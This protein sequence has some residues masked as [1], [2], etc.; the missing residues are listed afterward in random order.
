MIYVTSDLHGCHP[1]EFQRF[2]TQ[3]GFGD[4]DFLFILGDVIDRGEYGAELLLWL[5]EQPNMQ[6]ILGNHEALLL[7]CSFLFDEVTEESLEALNCE[8]LRLM[9]GWMKNGASPTIA[10]FRKL[11]RRDPELVAGILDY[12]QDAPLYEMLEI[13]G[14]KYVLVHAGLDNFHPA[15]P[16][17]DYAPDG[18]TWVRPDPDTRYFEDATVILGHTPTE[19]YGMEYRGRALH[20]DTWIDIDTGAAMGNNPMLLRLDDMREF[21]M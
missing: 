13:R 3:S 19:Y 9:E 6:L 12:L 11:L 17:D 2:L 18:L 10:G 21:Y 4:D 1:G 8:Q 16:M 5:T 15:R 14:K 7:A 20:T